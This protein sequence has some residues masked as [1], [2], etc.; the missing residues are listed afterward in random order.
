MMQSEPKSVTHSIRDRAFT[1]IELLVVIAIIA[2]LAAI[3]FPVFA[4]AKAAAKTT[5]SL[6][7][8][9]QIDVGVLMY[10]NDSDD[11]MPLA[12]GSDYYNDPTT[13]EVLYPYVKNTNLFWDV[14]GGVY[15]GPQPMVDGGAP[16]YLTN[17]WGWW[18]WNITLS[19]N[20]LATNWWTGS[21]YQQRTTSSQQY[22]AELCD[23]AVIRAPGYNNDSIGSPQWIGNLV[24]C[25]HQAVDDLGTDTYD[26]YWNGMLAQGASRHNN[27]ILASYIDGHAGHKAVHAIVKQ[28]C[29]E[30]STDYWNWYA[31]PTVAHFAGEYWDAND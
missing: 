6:S 14:S 8:L 27:Q 23:L 7:N 30:Y 4:Q 28:S 19:L 17:A 21:A 10:T 1:L 29:T 11:V 3:L 9:K 5:A 20:S 12:T 16:D 31:Q 24:I 18:D 25:S 13:L 15:P 2:I 22:P 26:N